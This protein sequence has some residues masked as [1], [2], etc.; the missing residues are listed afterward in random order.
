MCIFCEKEESVDL[1]SHNV[2]LD[3]CRDCLFEMKFNFKEN[4]IRGILIK[5]LDDLILL[6]D[7]TDVEIDEVTRQ[8]I[9]NTQD[10]LKDIKEIIGYL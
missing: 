9:K 3:I 2:L 6:P 4:K 10:R 1:S 5:A 8:I 7:D